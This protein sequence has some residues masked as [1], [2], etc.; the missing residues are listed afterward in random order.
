[1]WMLAFLF[2]SL[3]VLLLYPV[4]LKRKDLL[5]HVEQ[6]VNVLLVGKCW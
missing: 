3:R 5:S 1:M 4:H 6:S 2:L